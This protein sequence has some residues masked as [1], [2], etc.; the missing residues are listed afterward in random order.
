MRVPEPAEITVDQETYD[1]LMERMRAKLGVGVPRSG[2]HVSDLIYCV[3]KTW[4]KKQLSY[5]PQN[6]L[7]EEEDDQVLV[8]VVG[9]SHE[10]IF[11]EGFSRGEPAVLDGIVGTVDWFD[12][13]PVEAKSTR[14][15]SNR[16]LEEIPHYTAQAA[17]YC[18]M[19]E[20]DW[21]RVL[22]FHINGDYYHQ[23]KGGKAEKAM[24]RAHLRIYRVRFEADELEEW[25]E[26]LK[27]RKVLVEGGEKPRAEDEP[28]LIPVFDFECGYCKVGGLVNCPQWEG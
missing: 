1:R 27:R 24:P 10:D 26:E 16:H 2:T 23:T 20:T 6:V 8:W 17:A 15:S 9:R 22:I 3:L 11:G 12:E 19:H 21:C 28:D 5:L 4:A 7:E 14:M 18:V 25:W 13:V